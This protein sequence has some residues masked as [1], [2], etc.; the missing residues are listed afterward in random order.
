MY[1][2]GAMVYNAR[3]PAEARAERVPACGHE[4]VIMRPFYSIQY[5]MRV[6]SPGQQISTSSQRRKKLFIFAKSRDLFPFLDF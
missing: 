2:R 1:K 5:F 3:V 4:C 6:E